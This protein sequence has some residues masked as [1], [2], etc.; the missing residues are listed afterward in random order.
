MGRLV[1]THSTYLPGLIGLL[2][3]LANSKNI[4][5]ITP[6]VIYRTRG[7]SDK[8]R[9]KISTNICGGYK[10]ISRKGSLAQEVFMISDLSREEI[11]VMIDSYISNKR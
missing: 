2:K 4:K 1:L 6:G 9:I 7:R 8:F 5:S 10:L 11:N 3:S